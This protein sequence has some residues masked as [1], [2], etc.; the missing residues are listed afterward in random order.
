MTETERRGAYSAME[1]ALDMAGRGHFSPAELRDLQ[2]L[3]AQAY[4]DTMSGDEFDGRLGDGSYSQLEDFVPTAT[5]K[6]RTRRMRAATTWR[7]RLLRVSLLRPVL[8]WPG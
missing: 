6:M 5:M 3:F 4:R 2:R 8:R 1:H 7:C